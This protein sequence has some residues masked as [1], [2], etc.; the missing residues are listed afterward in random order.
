MCPFSAAAS[1]PFWKEAT[2]HIKWSSMILTFSKHSFLPSQFTAAQFLMTLHYR[3]SLF[4]SPEFSL[5]GVGSTHRICVP[6]NSSRVYY[7]SLVHFWFST[8]QANWQANQNQIF[9]KNNTNWEMLKFL[10]TWLPKTFSCHSFKI[11]D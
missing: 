4:L 8:I 3:V 11:N 6:L 1:V 7:Y 2:F 5:I 10:K 9:S